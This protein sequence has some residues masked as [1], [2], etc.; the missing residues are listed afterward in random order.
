MR[1]S[2]LCCLHQRKGVSESMTAK[3]LICLWLTRQFTVVDDEENFILCLPD[4]T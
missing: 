3:H 4:L 1:L 2:P